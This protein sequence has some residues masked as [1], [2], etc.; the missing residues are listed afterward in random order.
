M[1]CGV[2]GGCNGSAGAIH[3][4]C[5][6]GFPRCA[7]CTNADTHTHTHAHAHF[8][9]LALSHHCLQEVDAARGRLAGSMQAFDVAGADGPIDT[10]F[11]GEV[12]D[13]ANATF[14]TGSYGA[15]TSTDLRHWSKFQSFADVRCVVGWLVGLFVTALQCQLMVNRPQ[16]SST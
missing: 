5:D 12:I 14:W 1:I 3:L 8:R 15:S 10:F 2:W 7:R 16:P 9:S 6:D 4:S 11:E 13:D